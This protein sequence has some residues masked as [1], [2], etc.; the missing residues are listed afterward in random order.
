MLTQRELYNLGT[1]IE[2]H[3]FKADDK[4]MRPAI[5]I[6]NRA[7]HTAR[8]SGIGFGRILERKSRNTI[9]NQ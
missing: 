9:K 5:A 6:Y 7:N 2:D 4:M 3:G 8:R 1:I